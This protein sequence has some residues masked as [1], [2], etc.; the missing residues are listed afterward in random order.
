LQEGAGSGLLHEATP[1]LGLK[2][3]ARQAKFLNSFV[4]AF[5]D[6][7]GRNVFSGLVAPFEYVGFDR[8]ALE[9]GDDLVDQLRLKVDVIESGST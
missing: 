7:M 6:D 9:V 3:N 8:F 1:L 4:T 2:R 5:P